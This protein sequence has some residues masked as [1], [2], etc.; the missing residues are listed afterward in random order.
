D[1]NGINKANAAGPVTLDK[2]GTFFI[3]VA[4]GASGDEGYR[5]VLLVNGTVYRDTDDDGV[6]DTDDNCPG[7]SNPGQEDSDF[8]GVGDACDQCPASFLKQAPGVCGC[9]Q[10]DVDLEGDGTIDCG[11]TNP[12]RAM[13]SRRGLLLASSFST[14]MAFD[15]DSGN[16]V[17]ADFI[18]NNS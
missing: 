6:S 1:N 13:L 17:K 5:F 11:I 16:L 2:N 4:Q 10:P 3:H 14:V 12:A 8:D 18:T 9:D 7:V 15:P